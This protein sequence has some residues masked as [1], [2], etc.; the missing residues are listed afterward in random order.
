MLMLKDDGNILRNNF[1]IILLLSN[2]IYITLNTGFNQNDIYHY[3]MLFYLFYKDF[4]SN[5]L[6]IFAVLQLQI[7][8]WILYAI[9]LFRV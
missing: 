6:M 9:K 1:K 8:V 3:Y 2:I 5:Y 7:A 4:A